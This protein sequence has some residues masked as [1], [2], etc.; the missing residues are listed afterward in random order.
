MSYI[1]VIIIE[2]PVTSRYATSGSTAQLDLK[3]NQI[4]VGGVWFDYSPIKWKIKSEKST[5][6]TIL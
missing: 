1:N 3:N 6:Q 5:N 4:R 2:S